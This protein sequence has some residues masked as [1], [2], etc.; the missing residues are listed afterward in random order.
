MSR[1][2]PLGVVMGIVGDVRFVVSR[3]SLPYLPADVSMRGRK[4]M[5][6]RLLLH[7]GGDMEI[8]PPSDA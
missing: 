3:G 1:V 2:L 8:T 6:D 5:G 7:M 4:E